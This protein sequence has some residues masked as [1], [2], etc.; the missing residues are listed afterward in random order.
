MIGILL[1]LGSGVGYKIIFRTKLRDLRTV[2]LQTGR[3]PL[4]V[5]EIQELDDYAKLPKWRKFYSFIQLW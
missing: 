2:D 4:T 5:E 1:I 3:R